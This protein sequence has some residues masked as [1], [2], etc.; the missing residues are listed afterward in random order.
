MPNSFDNYRKDWQAIT[1]DNTLD[2][3]RRKSVLRQIQTVQA[4]QVQQVNDALVDS[5][6]ARV[7]SNAQGKNLD[8]IGRI[9]GV[10]PRPLV[11]AS[12]IAYLFA[13]DAQNGVDNAAMFVTNAPTSGKVMVGDLEYRRLIY[14]KIAK[15]STKYGSAPEIQY[16][17]KFAYDATI[18]VR[19]LGLSEIG[20]VF[21]A[22]TPA[23]IINQILAVKSDE[24]ADFQYTMPL[25]TTSRIKEV[26]FKPSIAFSPDSDLGAPDRA[27]IGVGNGI[28]A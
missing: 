15:N 2:I 4:D 26:F 28:N 14:A 21:E 3:F 7:V 6:L 22:A 9:V 12:T 13:D 5:L 23:N 11:D 1:C 8:V 17:A 27:Q 25:P 16:W 10:Y 19:N 20:I 24:T 18:S